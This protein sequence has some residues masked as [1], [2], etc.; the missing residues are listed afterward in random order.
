MYRPMKAFIKKV[1]H[2]RHANSERSHNIS[3]SLQMVLMYVRSPAWWVF[4][5]IWRLQNSYE[6][7]VLSCSVDHASSELSDLQSDSL[8]AKH[9]KS[10]FY[11]SLKEENFAHIRTHTQKMLALLKLR[12]TFKC[13]QT[14]SLRK[15]NKSWYS[16]LSAVLCIPSSDIEPNFEINWS[17][18]KRLE[19]S[20]RRTEKTWKSADEIIKLQEKQQQ[21]CISLKFSGF[22]CGH[23]GKWFAHLLQNESSDL[24]WL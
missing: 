15:L 8:L 3:L 13:K 16:H 7:I 24:Q 23:L 5:A 17:S 19:F 20:P 4:K 11:S 21:L 14:F 9:F 1:S 22:S 18:L 12:S 2:Q 6:W 10:D